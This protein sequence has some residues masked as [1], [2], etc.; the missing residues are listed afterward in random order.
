[1]TGPGVWRE[2][3]WR[4]DTA[5]VKAA[6]LLGILRGQGISDEQVLAAMARVPRDEFV[7]ADLRRHAWENR[8]LPIGAGQTI[9]QP[10]IVAYTTQVLG[11]PAGSRVLD[12][13][14]GCGYQAAVLAECGYRVHGVE[15]RPDLAGRA[16]TT[17]KR[18]GYDVTVTTGDGR[19]GL[20][21]YAPFDGIVVA[22]AATAV[23][24][25]LVAQLRN[26]G[27]RM[28]MPLGGPTQRLVLVE[29]TAGPPRVTDLLGV[30]FVPL[31]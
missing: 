19:L 11:L 8:P 4:R 28:I 2:E 16:S 9:S 1:M 17:L 14:T 25:A 20:P 10:F 22:A 18:L 27:G 12:V 24:G 6:D 13:G 15:I 23:P 5:L 7:P 21:E 26:P 3:R 30:L 29:P 31:V